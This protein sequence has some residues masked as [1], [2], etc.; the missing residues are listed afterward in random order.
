LLALQMIPLLVRVGLV[1]I[2]KTSQP[3]VMAGG[4]ESTYRPKALIVSKLGPSSSS[5]S[6]SAVTSSTGRNGVPAFPLDGAGFSFDGVASG[7]RGAERGLSMM[8]GLSIVCES[9]L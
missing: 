4:W 6:E 1:F 8:S 5:S 9:L 2:P 7:D 3:G